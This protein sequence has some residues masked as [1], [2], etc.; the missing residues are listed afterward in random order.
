M[1][2]VDI[3]MMEVRFILRQGWSLLLILVYPLILMGLLAPAFMVGDYS[4]PTVAL[5]GD[6]TMFAKIQD[7]GS[8]IVVHADNSEG[9]KVMVRTKKAALGIE[10]SIDGESGTRVYD[11]YEDPTKKVVTNSVLLVIDNIL[12]EEKE[13]TGE[14]LRALQRKLIPILERLKQKKAEIQTFKSQLAGLKED[15]RAFTSE[16]ESTGRTVD[17][18]SADISDF[19]GSLS[20]IDDYRGRLNQYSQDLSDISGSIANARAARNTYVYSIDAKIT[21]MDQYEAKVQTVITSLENVRGYL[22]PGTYPYVQVNTALNQ[23]Y[24]VRTDIRETRTELYQIRNDLQNIDFDSLYD[25]AVATRAELDSVNS[26]L[27]S[28]K[29]SSSAKADGI[30]R[31]LV[32]IRSKISSGVSR[33]SELESQMFVV[34][35]KV[36]ELETIINDVEAPLSN[37]VSTRPEDIMPPRIV[38]NDTVSAGNELTFFFP[39]VFAINALLASLLFPMI[40]TVRMRSQGVENRLKRAPV[41]SFSVILG[42]FFGDYLIIYCQMFLL[43]LFA[44]MLGVY[45]GSWLTTL[46]LLG[47]SAA[48]FTS[49][50]MFLAQFVNRSTTAF[51]LSLTIAIPMIFL[52]G[53][54][55]PFEFIKQP[56]DLFGKAMP[57]SVLMDLSEKYFFRDVGMFYPW[58]DLL[59]LSAFVLANLALAVIAY[60][61]KNQ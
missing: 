1:K 22:S 2:I 50:G 37:F 51:L 21:K 35:A 54:F 55:I 46:V 52:S 44:M 14:G 32:E 47:I 49:Q 28:L 11:I 7:S 27:G 43:T 19:K 41:S 8:F 58:E 61:I 13:E 4:K 30:D 3:G 59:Y 10:S 45:T 6:D 9:L 31:K 57:L 60:K 36:L 15:M 17:A 23:L 53:A 20:Q 18:F 33:A 39:S 42:R 25:K 40:V 48:V 34:Q 16:L 29:A 38:R 5:V 12:K 24:Q 56:M 26:D